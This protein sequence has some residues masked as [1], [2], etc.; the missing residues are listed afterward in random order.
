MKLKLTDFGR[1][2]PDSPEYSTK[3]QHYLI[4]GADPFYYLA[5]SA[6]QEQKRAPLAAAKTFTAIGT[7]S[8]GSYIVASI[9]SAFTSYDAIFVTNT[10]HFYGASSSSIIDLLSVPTASD[11]W[12]V[13]V[14]NQKIWATPASGSFLSSK[15]LDS[16]IGAWSTAYTFSSASSVGRPIK[17]FLD[18]MAF[19][20]SSGISQNLIKKVDTSGTFSTALNI[21]N[22]WNTYAMENYNNHYLAIV[23]FYASGGSGYI[24]NGTD[25]YVFLWNGFS[26]SYN[27]AIRSPGQVLDIRSVGANLYTLVLDRPGQISLYQLVSQSFKKLFSLAVDTAKVSTV[28]G[29]TKSS[30][31]LFDYAGMVGI[32]LNSK[33]QYLYTPEAK[34]ILTPQNLDIVTH[35]GTTGLLYGT[36]GNTLYSYSSGISPILYRSQWIPFAN[37]SS[38]VVKYATAPIGSSDTIQV[39][40]DGYDEDGTASTSLALSAITNTTFYNGYKTPLDTQGFQGKLVRVTLSTT[41]GGTW[42]PII[43]EIE[44]IS[45][46]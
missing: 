22:G 30:I 35:A 36:S 17:N 43:R 3:N 13:N 32:N 8:D 26:N 46:K 16:G 27:T 20:D 25:W 6:V 38:I 21:G 11:T 18:F 14:F 39:T 19:P 34:F 7:V 15:T 41:S 28:G 42:Q 23:A 10:G 40:L 31:T 4:S 37:P 9:Q 24:P 5:Q 12:V 29:T 33:G 44:L 2:N 1:M 45:P